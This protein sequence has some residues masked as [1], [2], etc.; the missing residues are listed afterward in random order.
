DALRALRA[1][2]ELREALAELNDELDRDFGMRIAVRTGVTSGEVIAGDARAGESF[3]TGEAVNVAQ[4]LQQAAAPDEILV[5]EVTYR[6]ARDAVV[7]EELEPLAVKGKRDP[8]A[9]FRLLEVHAGAPAHAPRFESPIVGR[10]R[11]RMLLADAY[12]RAVRESSCHLFTVLGPAGVGKSRLVAEVLAEIGDRAT[13]L[14]GSCL[15]YGEGITFWPV[16]EIVLQATGLADDDAEGVRSFIAARLEGD[17]D[18]EAVAELVAGLIGLGGEVG[19]AEET[20]WAVR[21]LLEALARRRPVVVVLDDVNWGEPTFLDLVEHVADW[22]RDAPILLVCLARPELLDLR[23]TWGGGKLNATSIL[24]EPLTEAESSRLIDNLLG[25]AALAEARERIQAAA[26]GNPLFVEEMLRMLVDDGLLRADDGTWVSTADLADV[27]VPTTI[28]ILL[29][30]RLDRLDDDERRVIE[31][32]SVEGKVFHRGAVEALSPDLGRERVDSCLLALM[33]KELVRPDRST[34]AGEDAFRFRHILIR[35]AA[36]EAVPK[37]ARAELHERFAD[38]VVDRPGEHDEFMGYHLEQAVRYRRDLGPTG[39]RELDLAR[40]AGAHLASAGRRALAR[41]DG[42]AAVNLLD[43]AASLLA[44]EPEARD[45]LLVDLGVALVL[46]G[47]LA[48]AES[49]LEEAAGRAADSGDESLAAHALLQRSFL[50]R[51]MHT[52]RGGEDLLAAAEGAIEVFERA[53]DD[54][55]LARAWRLCAEVHWTRCQIGLMED[56]LQRA[57]RHAERA[58]EQ[59]EVLL[60]LDGLA[61]AALVG[62][63]PVDEASLRCEEIA[64]R[65]TGRPHLE[66]LVAV[67]LAYLEAMRG[68]FEVARGEYARGAAILAELGSVVALAACQAWMGEVEMLA[69]DPAAA[70]ALRRTAFGTLEAL[71]ERGILSTVAAYLAETLYVLGRDEE[72]VRFTEVSEEAAADD[73]LASQVLWRSARAKAVVRQGRSGEAEGF[74]REAV[75]LAEGTDAIGLHADA[76][77]SLGAVLVAQGRGDEAASALREALAL[78]EAKGNV[79]SAAVVRRQ[80]D[81]SVAS[82]PTSTPP[83]RPGGGRS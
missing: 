43:R 10:S 6:L 36:Y 69:G 31:R 45:A 14:Q 3:V 1:V 67:N 60:I 79:V 82:V 13:I 5:G 65:A 62:R 57:L 2:V 48:C 15:A 56:A 26:E 77:A 80:L 53:E 41:G 71:G 9:A 22:A 73:D 54:E 8:V 7:V 11:E 46:A 16:R 83:L 55:G 75:G 21:H 70:E 58:G 66:G 64:Q 50:A 63:L 38:W 68:R 74:A 78:Y 51:Y 18:A 30:A 49:V 4:R 20:F 23:P 44:E 81:E 19:A 39:E 32:G 40:R 27:E 17:D 12:A 42:P 72:A 34:V 37:S 52:E 47:Q 33:R 25:R 28:R 59:Q 61:R 24:L 76:L 35:D 29:A